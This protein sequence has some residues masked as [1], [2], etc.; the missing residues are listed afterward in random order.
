MDLDS[1]NKF[2]EIGCMVLSLMLSKHAIFTLLK[3]SRLFCFTF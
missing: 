3:K 2:V 1:N